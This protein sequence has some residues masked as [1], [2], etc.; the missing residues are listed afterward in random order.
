MLSQFIRSAVSQLE[1]PYGWIGRTL[2]TT[3]FEARLATFD[4]SIKLPY[5]PLQS[6]TSV[7]YVDD[8][9]GTQTIS[10][11][12]YEA[13]VTTEPGYIALK[14]GQSWPTNLAATEYP[15]TITYV[16]GYGDEPEDVPEPVRQ[17]ILLAVAESYNRRELSEMGIV[18]TPNKFWMTMLESYRFRMG[19]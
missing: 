14:D 9:G 1:P 15:V 19:D 17:Y 13:V 6:V 7:K 4:G 8:D 2:I 11:S 16:A 12:V 3:I 18:L 5:P 10:T